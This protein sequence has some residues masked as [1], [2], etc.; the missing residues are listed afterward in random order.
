VAGW[1]ANGPQNLARWIA[2]PEAGNAM[3]D[4]GVPRATARPIADYLVSW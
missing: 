1:L 2:D 4:L 3:P